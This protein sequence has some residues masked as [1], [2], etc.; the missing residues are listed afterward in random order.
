MKDRKYGQVISKFSKS[1]QFDF[2]YS[3]A[4]RRPKEKNKP[5]AG[6]LPK[7]KIVGVRLTNRVTTEGHVED[8]ACV[9]VAAFTCILDRLCLKQNDD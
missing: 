7:K 8:H 2:D 9:C 3:V 4:R 6:R 1:I 5:R